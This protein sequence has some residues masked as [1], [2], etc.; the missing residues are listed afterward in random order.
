MA[1]KGRYGCEYGF[2]RDLSADI[3]GGFFG[4][5]PKFVN[6][7][8]GTSGMDFQHWGYFD[9]PL[10]AEGVADMNTGVIRFE[11]PPQTNYH[12]VCWF[13]WEWALT[14]EEEFREFRTTLYRDLDV[15]PT[16][17]I[18]YPVLDNFNFIAGGDFGTWLTD[19]PLP[20]PPFWLLQ[21]VLWPP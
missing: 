16:A 17:V 2:H 14:F 3:P 4:W 8:S 10:K 12:G 20:Y 18:N 19:F 6:I 1:H 13:A 9:P 5:L 11:F 7:S 15:S 21:G